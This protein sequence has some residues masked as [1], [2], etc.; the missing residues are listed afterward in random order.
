[1][2]RPAAVLF[3]NDG[4]LADTEPMWVEVEGE[5]CREIGGEHTAEVRAK[6][7]GNSMEGTA[8]VL[9]EAAG[10]DD[11]A[12]A[13]IS[14]LLTLRAIER[15]RDGNFEFMPGAVELLTAL[16]EAGIPLALVSAAD[17]RV[18]DAV[19]SRLPK[20]FFDVV[21][22]ADT[23]TRGKPDPEGYLMA[24]HALGVDP[25]D[26]LVIEDTANG[27]AAG[28]A[29]GAV[30]LAVPNPEGPVPPA[31]RRIFRDSLVGLTVDDLGVLM[32][33]VDG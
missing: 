33:R 15:L 12:V 13:D 10:R 26:C 7:L 21:V 29:S 3:D 30:V 28:N 6:T 16:D 19:T 17:T 11:L 8:A 18:L 20:Q 9:I 25:V 27:S 24:A 5:V 4:T 1:M 14:E 2:T 23:V 32:G 22:G 31:P